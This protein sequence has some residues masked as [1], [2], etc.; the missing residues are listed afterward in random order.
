MRILLLN[1]PPRCGK[2]TIASILKSHSPSFVHQEKFAQPMKRV[3]PLI[4]SVTLD[5]WNNHLDTAANKDLPCSEFYGKTP[6]EVQ[7]ALSEEYLKPLHSK[8]IFGQ[9][10]IR[11]LHM[12][13][14]GMAD[15]AVISDSGFFEEA[16]QVVEEFGA[17]NVQLWRIHREGCDFSKDSRNYVQLKDLGVREYDITNGGSLDDLRDLVVPLYEALVLPRDNTRHE[18]G[19]VIEESIGAWDT[20]RLEAADRAFSEWPDRR[21]ERIEKERRT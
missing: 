20:R 7:I 12:V 18:E 19:E 6:R 2:D 11:R 15:C 5:H 1:G 17:E 10:L 8:T 16:A 14:G 3:V 21:I 9:L 13:L 4:Y